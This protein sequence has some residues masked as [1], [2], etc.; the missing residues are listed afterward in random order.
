MKIIQSLL[1]KFVKPIA[2]A[3]VL[4][5]ISACS[6]DDL[7]KITVPQEAKS[8][9]V[10]TKIIEKRAQYEIARAK[11]IAESTDGGAENAEKMCKEAEEYTKKTKGN[12]IHYI[13]EQFIYSAA[14]SRLSSEDKLHLRRL[15][16]EYYRN[17]DLIINSEN[18]SQT[19]EKVAVTSRPDISVDL[20]KYYFSNSSTDLLRGY[21]EFSKESVSATK[22]YKG[23]KIESGDLVYVNGFALEYLN[24]HN[25]RKE[26]EKA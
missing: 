3:F 8:V 2:F 14:G 9:D 10:A 7:S 11:K 13:V 5:A 21:S 23:L 25:F 16:A 4:F 18:N 24:K 6:D 26:L 22:L 17:L 19:K 15:S 12:E 1:R 20:L